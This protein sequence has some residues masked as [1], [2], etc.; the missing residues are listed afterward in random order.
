MS[1]TSTNGS[2]TPSAGSASSPA[3]S[4]SR[5]KLSLKFCMNQL[6]R[7]TVHSAPEAARAVLGPLRLLLA[8]PRKQHEARRAGL[9]RPRGREAIASGAPGAA[10][11]G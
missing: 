7:T 1:S 4:G 8:A 5:K 6:Q 3:T 9:E 10:R 11:S 2:A